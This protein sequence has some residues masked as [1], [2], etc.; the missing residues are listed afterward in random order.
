MA[1]HA[2]AR[3]M[4]RA[5]LRRPMCCPW[6]SCMICP[7]CYGPHR[8]R[9]GSTRVRRGDGSGQGPQR[10]HHGPGLLRDALAVRPVY[11]KLSRLRMAA[12]SAGAVLSRWR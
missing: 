11:R 8:R 4:R 12:A 10:P 1:S 5:R 6:R 3:P 2:S 9:G 7:D